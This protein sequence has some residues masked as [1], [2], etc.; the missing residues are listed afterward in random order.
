M[1]TGFATVNNQGKALVFGGLNID[2]LGM[3]AAGYHPADS[4]PGSI[5]LSVGGVGFNIA[6]HLA[7]GG[8]AVSLVAALGQGAYA[9]MA[10]EACKT[11]GIDLSLSLRTQCPSPTYMAIHNQEG[12]MVAAINDM[13]AMAQLN[14]DYMRQHKDAFQQGYQVCVLDANLPEETLAVLPGLVSAPL[15]ADPVSGEKG[16]RLLPVLKKL[17]AIKPNAMEALVISRCEDVPSAAKWF[18]E[19]GVE[20]VYISLGKDGLHYAWREGEAHLP[21]LSQTQ[22]PS[23]GAGDAMAAGIALAIASGKSVPDIAFSGL[24]AAARYLEFIKQERPS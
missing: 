7:E 1:E 17:T 5:H 21:A 6:S 13:A 11:R 2:I 20:Q 4:L 3:P 22:V 14:P 18:L 8:M 9:H 10:E 23:T 16:R 15:L 19:Q 24:E 12:A